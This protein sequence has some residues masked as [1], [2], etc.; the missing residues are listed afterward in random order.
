MAEKYCAVL[1]YTK[2]NILNFQGNERENELFLSVFFWENGK[3]YYY[4]LRLPNAFHV[5]LFYCSLGFCVKRGLLQEIGI[6][7]TVEKEMR[8][9]WVFN[10]KFHQKKATILTC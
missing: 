1:V 3:I 2:Q 4:V 9:H 6:L 5:D 10:T 8:H 7:N